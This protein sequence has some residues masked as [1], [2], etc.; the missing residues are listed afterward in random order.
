MNIHFGD[1]NRFE[2]TITFSGGNDLIKIID[3]TT[4]IEYTMH[5]DSIQSTNTVFAAIINTRAALYNFIYDTFYYSSAGAALIDYNINSEGCLIITITMGPYTNKEDG[6]IICLYP[7]K[8][9]IEVMQSYYAELNHYKNMIKHYETFRRSIMRLP[10]VST[11]TGIGQPFGKYLLI[12]FI[13]PAGNRARILHNDI[14]MFDNASKFVTE[15]QI[16]SRLIPIRCRH[17]LFEC[18]H[19][20]ADYVRHTNNGCISTI[21]GSD[22]GWIAVDGGTDNIWNRICMCHI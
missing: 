10:S 3:S 1:D 11:S 2:V 5:D 22:D 14:A 9:M 19:P 8:T 13:D 16:C 18:D 17:V 7:N 21:T 4:H 12:L 15:Q 20:F 6:L